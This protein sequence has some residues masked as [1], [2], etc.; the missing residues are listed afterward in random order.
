MKGPVL[1]IV[2]HPNLIWQG[3]HPKARI[4]E[5]S[6]IEA[7]P[8]AAP[9]VSATSAVG[10]TVESSRIAGTNLPHLAA[11][12]ATTLARG[13]DGSATLTLSPE[14]LGHVRLA[15]QPDSQTPDRLF[16]M[17][18]FDRPETMDLFRRH[19]DQLAEALRS[20]GYAGV[21]IGFGG[22]GGD[23]SGQKRDQ[24]PATGFGSNDPVAVAEGAFA[25]APRHLASLGALDLR[26]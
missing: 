19:A 7:D 22:T 17:L 21:H 5:D 11:G 1:G 4:D 24:T 12:I 26:L 25:P 20:A 16:V 3:M 14:E 2:D 18:T 9:L 15:F 10:G 23:Q 6:L 8:T 13:H